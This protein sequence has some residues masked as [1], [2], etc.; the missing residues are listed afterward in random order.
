MYVEPLTVPVDVIESAFDGS[1]TIG[2]VQLVVPT[3]P[4]G[5]GDGVGVW[6]GVGAGVGVCVGVG[7][8]VGVG[9]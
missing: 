1:A 5:V 6:L 2:V 4:V 9:V 3:G 7:A 8:G